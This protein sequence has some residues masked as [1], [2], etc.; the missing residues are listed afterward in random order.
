MIN[1]SNISQISFYIHPYNC[2]A[3]Q[4]IDTNCSIGLALNH[5]KGFEFRQGIK[6]RYSH[7]YAYIL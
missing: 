4:L 1:I 2:M 7:S 3:N 5:F 6:L